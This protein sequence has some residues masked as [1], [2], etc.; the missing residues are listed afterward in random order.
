MKNRNP[1]TFYDFLWAYI[2]WQT[3]I[4]IPEQRVKE[5]WAHSEK[6]I[7]T[8]TLSSRY[9]TYDYLSWICGQNQ[10]N[11]NDLW[12]LNGNTTGFLRVC[13]WTGS[14][15]LWFSLWFTFKPSFSE[16]KQSLDCWTSNGENGF[17][18]C[19]RPFLSR[20][21]WNLQFSC[22]SVM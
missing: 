13:F 17:T 12:K 10:N 16:W 4:H 7:D 21:S 15:S 18:I 11:I 22:C 3:I 5:H 9:S 20:L 1:W 2:W 14:R 19:R 8:K 6:T